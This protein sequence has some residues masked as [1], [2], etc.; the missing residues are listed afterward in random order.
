MPVYEYKCENCGELFEQ[1]ET[2][3]EHEASTPACHKC[4]SNNLSRV[5]SSI[6]VKTAKKS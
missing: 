5:Y 6:Q 4:N 3:A 1:T 2:L